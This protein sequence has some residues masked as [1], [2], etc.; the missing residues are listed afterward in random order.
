MK[1]YCAAFW[2]LSG[3]AVAQAT[4]PAP[5][6]ATPPQGAS[7]SVASAAGE[8]PADAVIITIKGMCRDA[9]ASP[10]E[11]EIKRAEFDTLLSAL[12]DTRGMSPDQIPLQAK[13]QLAMQYAHLLLF[14]QEAEKLGL[15]R[16]PEAQELFRFARLQVLDQ[17]MRSAIQQKATPTPEEIQKHYQANP[18]RYSELTLQR[19]TIPSRARDGSQPGAADMHK[20]ADEIRQRAA[21]GADFKSLQ[22]EAYEK[23]GLGNPPETT[24]TLRSTAIPPN[25]REILQLKPGEISQVLQDPNAYY[26]Y[27]LD[28]EQLLPLDQVKPE[29]Q[30]ELTTQNLQREFEG[31][32][33]AGTPQLDPKY[34]GPPTPMPAGARPLPGPTTP[35][36]AHPPGGAPPAA[37]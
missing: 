2:L 1:L 3:I 24:M 22:A 11:T 36:P 5:S 14:A 20:L 28:K 29:I 25:H 31:L 34:F 7:P 32:T 35:P 27:K 6:P 19:I 9:K 15:E 30:G 18:T 13:R 33:R 10:C 26:I 17:L 23:A 12:A 4:A 21:A 8:V 37:K 16:G